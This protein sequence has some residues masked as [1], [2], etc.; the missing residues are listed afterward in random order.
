MALPFTNSSQ[1][2]SNTNSNNKKKMSDGRNEEVPCT[3]TSFGRQLPLKSSSNEEQ[4]D[5][6]TALSDDHTS[7]STVQEPTE[8]GDHGDDD[9]DDDDDFVLAVPRESFNS[10]HLEVSHG[11]QSSSGF[12][13]IIAPQST[14]ESVETS[15]NHNNDDDDDA[16]DENEIATMIESMRLY[17]DNAELL[18]KACGALAVLADVSVEN[19]R[20]IVFQGG[21]ETVVLAMQRFPTHVDLQLQACCVTARLALDESH[22]GLLGSDHGA[23]D[24][25]GD[26]IRLIVRAMEN[27]KENIDLEGAAVCALANLAVNE[28]NQKRIATKT[29]GIESI[30]AA[31]QRHAS[32][33]SVQKFGFAALANLSLAHA[34]NRAK[35]AA[36]NG[37]NV[38]I[39]G[40]TT[41][42]TVCNVQYQA[43]RALGSIAFQS[44]SIGRDIVN[45]GGVEAI[46]TGMER[47]HDDRDVQ[48]RACR[49]LANL[50]VN[51]ENRQK[52][53]ETR[54]GKDAFASVLCAMQEH[55]R[56]SDIQVFGNW[57]L[58]N[59][60]MSHTKKVR[61]TIHR[62]ESAI[63]I[64][65]A[66]MQAHPN[67]RRVQ[68]Q[69][70]QVL[71][72]FT[73]SYKPSEIVT[74]GGK[75]VALTARDQFGLEYSKKLL[76]RLR[77]GFPC[78]PR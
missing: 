28:D 17:S 4:D 36:H 50:A 78:L 66:A 12:Q 60:A 38:I 24:G 35:I 29:N 46:V 67:D 21:I 44:Q 70:C 32:V 33:A 64:V 41:H 62:T 19:R 75:A 40:M 65:V 16:S 72:F 71:Y 47:F 61:Q 76:R 53:I 11:T 34:D 6:V 26:L 5:G 8:S 51:D 42:A 1:D 20:D 54:N 68:E 7:T 69:G 74:A 58:K 3:F 49:A 63:D 31:L 43:F 48:Y 25:N 27:H 56:D 23:A 9:D 15:H 57:M 45:G 39:R 37:I 14:K 2:T 18:T 10:Q 73:Y 22:R 59:F 30:T 52:M 55:S 13:E 77:K